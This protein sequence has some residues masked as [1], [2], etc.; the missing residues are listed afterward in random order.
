MFSV[1]VCLAT[2]A[3]NLCCIIVGLCNTMSAQ[4]KSNIFCDIQTMF[5][6]IKDNSNY[7]LRSSANK[8]LFVPRTHHKSLSYTGVI[9]WNALPENIKS[10]KTFTKFKNLYIKKTLEENKYR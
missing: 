3:I 2:H 7:S 1:L 4:H 9:I 8:K 6:N 10:S 5:T